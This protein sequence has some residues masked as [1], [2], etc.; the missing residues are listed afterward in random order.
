LKNIDKL[1]EKEPESTRRLARE[2]AKLF[3]EPPPKALRAS[4]DIE[5]YTPFKGRVPNPKLAEYPIISI[6]IAGSDGFKKVYVLS[7][8]FKKHVYL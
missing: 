2:F 3:E 4:I 8:P 6:A 5:V 1:F 7:R